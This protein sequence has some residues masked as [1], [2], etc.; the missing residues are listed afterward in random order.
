L[1]ATVEEAVEQI[2][3]LN[4]VESLTA[5]VTDLM[6]AASMT[7]MIAVALVALSVSCWPIADE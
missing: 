2:A 1:T 4:M 6:F 3:A 7:A 5:D